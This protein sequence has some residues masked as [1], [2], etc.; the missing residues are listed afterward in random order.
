[1]TAVSGDESIGNHLDLWRVAVR[2]IEDHP[3]FGTGPETYPEEFPAYSRVVLAPAAVRYFDQYRVESPHDEVLAIGAGSG[4]PAALA[5]LVILGGGW[6]ILVRQLRRSESPT[7]RLA[8]IAVLAASIGHVVTDSFMSAEVTGSWLFWVLLGA[9]VGSYRPTS[10]NAAS[11]PLSGA[12]F[13][14]RHDASTSGSSS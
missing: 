3:L 14:S 6:M 11:R 9:A 10:D 8:M 5:Y 12:E 13:G 4:I 2:M 1:V 7:L